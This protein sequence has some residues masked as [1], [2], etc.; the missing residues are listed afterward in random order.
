MADLQARVR[1]ELQASLVHR[2]GT[3][4]SDDR[5]FEIVE[6]IFRRALETRDHGALL[7]PE[8]LREED[9]WRLDVP[10]RLS[11]HRARL[12][13]PILFFKRRVLLPAMRWLY[14]YAS[15]NFRRQQRLNEILFASLQ[16]LA[17]EHARLR[18]ELEAVAGECRKARS[19]TPDRS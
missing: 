17:V 15:G 4:L 12:G 1:H 9:D 18:R 14:E 6:L 7:L 16:T 8:I 5:I 13:G 19:G 3:E 2:G 11:S 10:L